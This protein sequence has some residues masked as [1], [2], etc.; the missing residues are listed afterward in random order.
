MCQA[1]QE[2]GIPEVTAM[3]PENPGAL[4][5]KREIMIIPTGASPIEMPV[6]I[7]TEA[8]AKRALSTEN[9]KS[10]YSCSSQ[11]TILARYSDRGAGRLWRIAYYFAGSAY[12]ATRNFF[13]TPAPQV[14]HRSDVRTFQVIG[15][16]TNSSFLSTSGRYT[17]AEKGPT[18]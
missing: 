9:C 5:Y 12:V 2:L 13:A 14:V 3:H 17:R 6:I 7:A 15:E 1:A 4:T 18:Q 11:A 10:S 16:R 8:K